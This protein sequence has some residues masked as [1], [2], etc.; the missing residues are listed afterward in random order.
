MAAMKREGGRGLSRT[1]RCSGEAI[2]CLAD[3]IRCRK[4]VTHCKKLRIQL[5]PKKR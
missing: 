5:I 3:S 2:R 4:E 1:I